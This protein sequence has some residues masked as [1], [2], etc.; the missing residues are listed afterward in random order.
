[1]SPSGQ[2][3][4]PAEQ[5]DDPI[6]TTLT[7]FNFFLY[8]YLSN[9]V[10][11][12]PDSTRYV[13]TTEECLAACNALT[14]NPCQ[15]FTYLPGMT[16]C[17]M[18]FHNDN[19][20]ADALSALTSNL[21]SIST[22]GDR[23]NEYGGHFVY[24]WVRCGNNYPLRISNGYYHNPL[25]PVD[26]VLNEAATKATCTDA[27][28]TVPG[29]G[30]P[31]AS[32]GGSEC[33]TYD[34]QPGDGS[35]PEAT[36]TQDLGTDVEDGSSIGLPDYQIYKV[37]TDSD[38][39]D[40]L[41]QATALC[42]SARS[43]GML[44]GNYPGTNT[45]GG[46]VFPPASGGEMYLT[47]WARANGVDMQ[48]GGNKAGVSVCGNDNEGNFIGRTFG[49]NKNWQCSNG[50][51]NQKVACIALKSA[52]SSSS[53]DRYVEV[54]SISEACDCYSATCNGF[55]GRPYPTSYEDAASRCSAAGNECRG[56]FQHA[57]GPIIML[58]RCSSTRV[59]D[60][61][62]LRIWEKNVGRRK[63]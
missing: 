39:G 1:M 2:C 35:C 42:A 38:I 9:I 51:C 18:Y 37:T 3:G 17:H 50:Q 30:A 28:G 46:R 60:N 6:P 22:Y 49:W 62:A 41:D 32:N 23:T 43:G 57:D 59:A 7:D 45:C 16:H 52:S 61:N 20:V 27:C 15:A 48:F 13:G 21:D 55:T 47:S 24:T 10:S 25:A 12:M 4:I 11:G 63:L 34:C 5:P 33:A 58:N 56:Y 44:L 29:V 40:S 26:C 8:G 14:P 53:S 31:A 19:G 36:V 54:T